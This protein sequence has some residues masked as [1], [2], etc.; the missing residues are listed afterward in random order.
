MIENGKALEN[1][2][3]CGSADV[4]LLDNDESIEY[5][6][7]DQAVSTQELFR[8]NY[9][10][11]I[12]TELR[13]YG[14]VVITQGYWNEDNYDENYTMFYGV[15]PYEYQYHLAT[16]PEKCKTPSMLRLERNCVE[17]GGPSMFFEDS[18]TSSGS[19]TAGPSMFFEDRKPKRS[20]K[21]LK[22]KT[23]VKSVP[24]LKV[25]KLSNIRK[26]AKN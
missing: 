9:C 15:T 5:G 18:S 1:C 26:T 19:G 8:C 25:R 13:T 14:T 17:A 12:F 6:S 16:H 7:D 20:A 24:L 23:K 11:N 4:T 10:H 21:S 3:W 22:G 2:P